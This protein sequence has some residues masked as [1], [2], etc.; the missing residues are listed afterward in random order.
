MLTHGDLL[1]LDNHLTSNSN[2]S[3]R[4]RCLH[5][6]HRTNNLLNKRI[7][8]MRHLDLRLLLM[9]ILK[10]KQLNRSQFTNSFPA[11]RQLS[12][13]FPGLAFEETQPGSRDGQAVG[14]GE[15]HGFESWQMTE[16]FEHRREDLG[17][18][19]PVVGEVEGEVADVG[20]SGLRKLRQAVEVFDRG[21]L[22]LFG[23]A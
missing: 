17:P 5:I 15:S 4:L 1:L 9:V 12:R 3:S 20:D 19:L 10:L 16:G 6:R 8:R 13:Q 7:D 22:P 23:L 11:Q 14:H 2:S 21:G 18:E